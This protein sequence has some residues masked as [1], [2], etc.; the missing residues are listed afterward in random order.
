MCR[1]VEAK[2]EVNVSDCDTEVRID[3]FS[4]FP[5]DPRGGRDNHL[6]HKRSTWHEISLVRKRPYPK[7]DQVEM[8]AGLS[9]LSCQHF[10]RNELADIGARPPASVNAKSAAYPLCWS[11]IRARG[12]KNNKL[13][14]SREDN[15]MMPACEFLRKEV[16]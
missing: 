10:I 3:F 11:S 5:R 13:K 14:D 9:V 12:K 2:K 16:L 1:L 6:A 7:T 4:Y 15:S 8:P